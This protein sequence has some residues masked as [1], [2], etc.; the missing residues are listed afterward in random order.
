M[1]REWNLESRR[2]SACKSPQVNKEAAKDE[3]Q[4]K[5]SWDSGVVWENSGY[6]K[7]KA[8][9]VWGVVRA[10]MAEAAFGSITWFCKSKSFPDFALSSFAYLRR[11]VWSQH[12]VEIQ[13]CKR[14]EDPYAL[15]NYFHRNFSHP[16]ERESLLDPCGSL[17]TP[18]A[19]SYSCVPRRL[20]SAGSW[21]HRSS[22]ACGRAWAVLRSCPAFRS[23]SA[24]ATR[25]AGRCTSGTCLWTPGRGSSSTTTS[26]TSAAQPGT[27]AGR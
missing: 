21:I 24:C 27:A 17:F 25:A 11:R 22:S 23:C 7:L 19:Q 13:A 15:R 1:S 2:A 18:A 10:H 6:R 4:L 14:C 26:R 3:E 16:C 8:R 5:L 12:L 20:R 9:R